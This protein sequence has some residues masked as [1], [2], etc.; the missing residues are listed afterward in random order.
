MCGR[1]ALAGDWSE[2]AEE[3]SLDEVPG[4]PERYNIAPSSSAGFEVPIVTRG[5]LRQARFW[6]I[7]SWW[8]EPLKKLPTS[9]NARSETVWQKPLFR[10]ASRCLVPLSGWREFPGPAGKKRAVQ[11]HRPSREGH[12][13][14]FAFGG[15]CTQWQEPKTEKKVVSFGILTTEP[16]EQVAVVHHRMPLL[17]NRKDYRAWLSADSDWDELL[18]AANKES[19]EGPLTS[20]EASIFGNSTQ[21][22]GPECIARAAVQQ[23]LF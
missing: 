1:Y 11:F 4:M 8:T 10:G 6:F 19:Q 16:N 9:F 23:S 3:F 15:V 12:Q 22:Q 13:P 17:I 20:Y 7:P 14:F 21:N 5:G 2:F 18:E